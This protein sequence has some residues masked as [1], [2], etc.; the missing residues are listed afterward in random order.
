VFGPFSP[1][2]ESTRNL[3][4]PFACP[5]IAAER[6]IP[7]DDHQTAEDTFLVLGQAFS[8]ALG[9]RQGIRRFGDAHV[10][11]DEALARAVLDISSRPFF[12]GIF[13]FK[14]EKIGSL[15]TQV[16]PRCFQGFTKAAGLTVHVDVLRGEKDQHRADAAIRAF[17]VACRDAAGR[18][19]G[20]R[21]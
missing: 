12:V 1:V 20:N 8:K 15:A 3:T 9:D 21:D 2:S 19:T 16:I 7:A 5:E 18:I 10:P 6:F 13:G 14:D 11:V 4:I 17:A